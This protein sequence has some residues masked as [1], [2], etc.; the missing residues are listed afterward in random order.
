MSNDRYHNSAPR[1]LTGEEKVTVKDVASR[2]P[3]T[4]RTDGMSVVYVRRGAFTTCILAWWS[5]SEVASIAIGSTILHPKDKDDQELANK[6]SLERAAADVL[7]HVTYTELG[8]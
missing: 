7:R 1:A 6:I 4:I 5:S 8:K 2:M 3:V